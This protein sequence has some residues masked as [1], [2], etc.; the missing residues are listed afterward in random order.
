MK[1]IF[2]FWEPKDAMPAYIKLCIETW[3]KYLPDYEVV[4]LDYSNYED[5]IGKDCY[6]SSLRTNFSLPKQA[7][8]IRA[9]VLN[10]H[11]GI[12]MD[13]D[14]IVL[15]S[16]I[17]DL[18]TTNTEFTIISRHIAVLSS[19]KNSMIASH[20]M[21]ECQSRINKYKELKEKGALTK[22]LEVY[23]YLG[24][25]PINDLLNQVDSS[26]AVT[27]D[28][29]KIFA[30][31]ECNFYPKLDGISAYKHF[32]F[33]EN[34]VKYLVDHCKIILLHNSWT[35]LEFKNMSKNDFLQ[36]NCT[37][38]NILRYALYKDK[39][40]FITTKGD[41]NSSRLMNLIQTFYL[42]KTI[43]KNNNVKFI[44]PKLMAGNEF[45]KIDLY[46]KENKDIKFPTILDKK[47]VFSKDFIEKYYIDIPDYKQF[48]AF[49][50][51]DHNYKEISKTMILD[52]Q[53][54]YFPVTIKNLEEFCEDKIIY[55]KQ[56]RDIWQNIDFSDNIKRVINLAHMQA[57]N[58]NS[59]IVIHM[60]SGDSIYI[61]SI[62]RKTRPFEYYATN[63][64][65]VLFI[66]EQNLDKEIFI[67]SDDLP[68]AKKLSKYIN[69]N[70]IKSMQDIY[71]NINYESFNEFEQY[72]FDVIF[73]SHAS[74]IYGTS[75]PSILANLIGNNTELI[76]T[77]SIGT[78]NERFD[79]SVKTTDSLD[80]SPSQKAFSMLHLFLLS[81]QLKKDKILS[82]SFL[83]KALH[84]DE[85]NDKY[86]IYIVDYFLENGLMDEAEEYLKNVLLNRK[87]QFLSTLFFA[88]YYTGINFGN[89]FARYINAQN[90]SFPYISF[91]AL[92]IYI[93]QKHID[94]AI[95]ISKNFIDKNIS[96]SKMFIDEIC[97]IFKKYPLEFNKF[98][99][100]KLEINK[101]KKEVD[102]NNSLL[103]SKDIELKKLQDKSSELQL[104]LD[105]KTKENM[106]M[107]SKFKSLEDTLNSYPIKKQ[108]LEISNLEQDL[109]NKKLKAQIL[110]K[111]LGLDNEIN[112]KYNN[113]LQENENLK[114][115]LSKLNQEFETNNPKSKS[116]N[117]KLQK[118]N[119]D[120]YF[121]L[122]Y[123]T[124]KSRIKNQLSYKL[125][126]AMIANSKSLLG[127]IR[128][129]YVL[130][131][132]KDMHKKEQIAYN[133]KI[134]ANPSLKLPPIESYPD[135]KEA[136]KEKECLTY[137]LGEAMI[138]A[139]K[140]PLKLGYLSLWFKCKNIT[141]EHKDNHKNSPN[142][143]NH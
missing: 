106:Q 36:T 41:G 13:A 28:R 27:L 108:S 80:L 90:E 79:F 25:G 136:L 17:K 103:N 134:K 138:E 101:L 19:I 94:K 23:Y 127:Y 6:D 9:A 82:I 137:K 31:P 98:L 59:F 24:N 140:S 88:T 21:K 54:D 123:G 38:S 7:D 55:K 68:S 115:Q 128:M 37:L 105:E 91:I 26:K 125:G 16:E 5:W 53:C 15:S 76:N 86:R 111:E 12:W 61:P 71:K 135:Y 116:D 39:P 78:L 1:K 107:L 64:E 95:L 43:S 100:S 75:G 133:E 126:E 93:H 97:E 130:S 20:W 74:T 73:M 119:T 131:Y 129:P 121:A 124:A 14:T 8:A 72:I 112:L 4:I 87:D 51:T 109:I 30:V 92:K 77:Y 40:F 122:N 33:K 120:L 104:Q 141:K 62:Y 29:L 22:D 113:A 52:F 60:R 65:Q 142:N 2:T 10:K 81:K 96:E 58:Y 46:T 44:W 47:E 143:S 102:S 63:A 110:E 67:V 3:K 118:I 42:A 34:N 45:E 56:I 48:K 99:D 85:D 18:F 132:I 139:D 50:I 83:N 70:N 114:A 84:Y 11:G 35:P 66:I 57:E 69:K 49:S 117:Q 89:L 32:Y